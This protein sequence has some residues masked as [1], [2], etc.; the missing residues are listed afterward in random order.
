MRLGYHSKDMYVQY[1]GKIPAALLK[2]LD[3]LDWEWSPDKESRWGCYSAVVPERYLK[4]GVSVD[5]PQSAAVLPAEQEAGKE[6]LLWNVS[7][8]SPAISSPVYANGKVFTI[9]LDSVSAFDGRTGKK[10]WEVP[11]EEYDKNEY[12]SYYANKGRIA[13]YEGVLYVCA[14]DSWVYSLDCETGN[15]VW[16]YRVNGQSNFL[17]SFY[18]KI[19]V[20]CRF[21]PD[22]CRGMF[23]LDRRTGEKIWEVERVTSLETIDEDM[24]LYEPKIGYWTVIDSDTGEE[25]WKD[26]LREFDDVILSEGR[27]YYKMQEE[28]IIVCKDVRSLEEMWSF[29]YKESCSP[30]DLR[31]KKLFFLEATENGILLGTSVPGFSVSKRELHSV[32]LLDLNGAVIWSYYYPP[33]TIEYNSGSISRFRIIQDRGYFTHDRGVMDVF[34]LKAGD[35]LWRTEVRGTRILDIE[36]FEHEYTYANDG[37]IYCLDK[38]TGE[39]LWLF[40]TEKDFAKFSDDFEPIF[41]SRIGDG[42]IFIATKYGNVFAFSLYPAS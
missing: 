3:A 23:C 4:K 40:E 8:G 27:V 28:N 15:V 39:I 16:K 20:R 18:D 5:F 6:H 42:L 19:I 25:L 30:T 10:V 7:L 17:K 37:R 2:I 33:K 22:G 13:A 31:E 34:D 29:D 32:T 11:F 1:N 21:S 41:A 26:E 24:I 9:S 14:P 36:V 38:D 12:L 35:R